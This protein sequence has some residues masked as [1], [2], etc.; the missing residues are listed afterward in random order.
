MRVL[1]A[2]SKARV[3]VFDEPT[4]ALDEVLTAAFWRSVRQVC[5]M[6]VAVLAVTHQ[7]NEVEELYSGDSRAFE[8]DARGRIS[9][10]AVHLPSIST[11]AQLF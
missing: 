6:G 2:G 1:A 5:D 9:P 8:M 4:S 3:M 10:A 7:P 11:T